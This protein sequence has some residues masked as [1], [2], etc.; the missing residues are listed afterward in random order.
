ML[1]KCDNYVVNTDEIACAQI[2]DDKTIIR[3]KDGTEISV[4]GVCLDEIVDA[5]NILTTIL[6][7]IGNIECGVE[8]INGNLDYI[9]CRIRG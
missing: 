4:I 7:K 8:S 3:L 1:I 5:D 9:Y 6:D 2:V